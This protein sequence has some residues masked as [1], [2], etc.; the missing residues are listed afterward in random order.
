MV[1]FV[2]LW[3]DGGW[4]LGS[5]TEKI[6]DLRRSIVAYPSYLYV[7]VRILLPVRAETPLQ[8]KLNDSNKP[9]PLLIG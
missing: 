6:Q 1:Q 5:T 8:R 4:I 7:P 3:L 9:Q 2:Q